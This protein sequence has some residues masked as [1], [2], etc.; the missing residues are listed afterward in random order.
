M[1]EY[2]Q[3]SQQVN[4]TNSFNTLI[5]YSFE[6]FSSFDLVLDRTRSQCTCNTTILCTSSRTN[7]K[8]QQLSTVSHL[9]IILFNNHSPFMRNYYFHFTATAIDVM[10]IW[11]LFPIN[12]FLEL[13]RFCFVCWLGFYF[14]FYFECNLNLFTDWTMCVFVCVYVLLLVKFI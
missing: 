10:M 4:E 2:S 5:S 12:K 7:N 14:I 6:L 1:E 9:F 11:F 8:F 13:F 3:H